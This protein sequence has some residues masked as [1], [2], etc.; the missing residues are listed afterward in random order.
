MP[1]KYQKQL[2]QTHR[3]LRHQGFLSLKEIRTNEGNT[4][5]AEIIR[6]TVR[7]ELHNNNLAVVKA[8]GNPK[9]KPQLS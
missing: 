5:A 9:G 1:T 2:L 6:K 3:E 8:L 7:H 4:K